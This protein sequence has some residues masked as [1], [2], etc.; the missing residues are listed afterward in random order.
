MY[1]NDF[2]EL[3]EWA[4]QYGRKDLILRTVTIERDLEDAAITRKR[5]LRG[6]Y[7]AIRQA[8]LDEANR[9]LQARQD[10]ASQ[11]LHQ[12]RELCFWLSTGNR[13][14]GMSDEDYALIKPLIDHYK[15]QVKVK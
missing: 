8:R 4:K 9:R 14:S 12:V 13:G 6:P 15:K 7:S 5:R 11:L 1:F 2:A 3:I 10:Q